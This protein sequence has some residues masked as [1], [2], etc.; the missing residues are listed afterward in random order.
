MLSFAKK[1]P[2]MEM[3]ERLAADRLR[4]M[5]RRSW[6]ENPLAR[7]SDSDHRLDYAPVSAIAFHV[8]LDI[9]VARVVAFIRLRE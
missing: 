2:S 8:C 4:L 7:N 9:R 5:G 1:A 6:R 3:R